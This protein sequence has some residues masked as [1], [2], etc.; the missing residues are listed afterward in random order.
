M[1]KK[2]NSNNN[3]TAFILTASVVVLALI[4]TIAIMGI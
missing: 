1:S 3:E 4:I 2:V